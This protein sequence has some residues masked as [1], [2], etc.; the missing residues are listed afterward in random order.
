[1]DETSAAKLDHIAIYVRDADRSAAFYKELFD[2]RQVPAPVP[3]ARWL[4]L[5]D[6]SMLH[7]VP[8]RPSRVTNAR[9]DHIAFA[10]P[11]LTEMVRRLEARKLR[12]SDINDNP[13]PQTRPDGVQQIFI[14]DPDGYWIEI[15]DGLKQRARR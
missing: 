3:F 12:W 1:M 10:V 9:W 2:L 13:A 4:M 8:G 14:Q 6:G 11:D 5:A 7:I 15:N